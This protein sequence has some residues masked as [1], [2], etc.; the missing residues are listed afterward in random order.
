[1]SSMRKQ[2]SLYETVHDSGIFDAD[3]QAPP[4]LLF[5]RYRAWGVSQSFSAPFGHIACGSGRRRT[6]DP[7]RSSFSPPPASINS[8]YFHSVA[9]RIYQTGKIVPQPL[10]SSQ[11]LLNRLQVKENRPSFSSNINTILHLT[12]FFDVAKAREVFSDKWKYRARATSFRYRKY[13]A[14]IRPRMKGRNDQT[15]APFPSHPA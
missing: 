11:S 2:S 4:P 9:M 6:N 14:C 12:H 3:S 15:P 1:M 10:S 13:R 8:Y 5:R 7:H